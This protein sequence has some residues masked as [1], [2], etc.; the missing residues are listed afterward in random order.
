MS[1]KVHSWK[2]EE[3]IEP[4]QYTL[5]YSRDSEGI[6]LNSIMLS[7]KEWRIL[8]EEIGKFLWNMEWI[9]WEKKDE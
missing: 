6:Q 7:M 3:H 2:L 8:H 4:Q 9:Q 5:T 1:F